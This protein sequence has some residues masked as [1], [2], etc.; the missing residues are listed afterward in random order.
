MWL[1]FNYEKKY[2]LL[3]LCI[4]FICGCGGD[5]DTPTNPPLN[6]QTGKYAISYLV[7][8][9]DN[10]GTC[11]INYRIKDKFYNV[12]SV[13]LPWTVGFCAD[14]NDILSF[15]VSN[16]YLQPNDGDYYNIYPKIA[17]AANAK[18]MW[19]DWCSCDS[20]DPN[21]Q[22]TIEKKLE[23]RLVSFLNPSL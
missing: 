17:V 1:L 14:A 10:N 4:I 8:S 12:E 16:I 20:T 15:T 21:I 2:L 11:D 9:Y 13:D 22:C 23:R 7:R 6:Y 19:Y 3:I 5:N 18:S